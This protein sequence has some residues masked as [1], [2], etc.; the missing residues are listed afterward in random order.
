M[1][2]LFQFE[3]SQ[4]LLK[5]Y[6]IFLKSRH[7]TEDRYLSVREI[8]RLMCL[9]SLEQQEMPCFLVLIRVDDRVL[10]HVGMEEAV[11]GKLEEFP[12]HADG[13]GKAEGGEGKEKG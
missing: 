8:M 13:H 3:S 9:P 2:H 7:P 4:D 11:H 5:V 10:L 1:I 6:S 12:Q